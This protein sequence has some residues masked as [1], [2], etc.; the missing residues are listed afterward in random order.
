M[1]E[2]SPVVRE[3]MTTTNGVELRTLEAGQWGAPVV[4]LA[5]GCPEL[6]FSWRHQLPALAHAGFHVLAPDQRGYGGSSRPE[7]LRDY[8]IIALTTDLLGL[9]DDVGAE[10]A[11]FVGD[12]WGAIVAWSQALLNPRRVTAVVGINVPMQPRAQVPPLSTLAKMFASKFSPWLY[13]QE[14]GLADADMGRDVA[15]TMRRLL[16]HP[17]SVSLDTRPGPQGFVDRFPEPQQL[18]TWLSTDE[19]DYY[20]TEFSRT[21]FTGGLNWY[22]NIDRNWELTDH[23]TNSKVAVPSLFIGGAQDPT[24]SWLPPNAAAPLLTRHHGDII[25]DNAGHWVQ[26]QQPQSVNTALIEFLR[27]THL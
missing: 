8:D 11:A 24:L 5:H 6:A 20:I 22:R 19:L 3:R 14:P 4:V 18:P 12:D 13:F 1:S 10:R 21:G 16:A 7:A 17:T 23:L 25:I 27:T 9:L 26:Q 2:L 15:T